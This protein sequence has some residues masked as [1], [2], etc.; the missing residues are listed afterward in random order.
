MKQKRGFLGTTEVDTTDY[1]TNGKGGQQLR[2]NETD[3]YAEL[4]LYQEQLALSDTPNEDAELYRKQDCIWLCLNA[5]DIANGNDELLRKGGRIIADMRVSG[6]LSSP[7]ATVNGEN[8]LLQ[9]LCDDLKRRMLSDTDAP[10]ADAEF[11]EWFETEVVA[12]NYYQ[13]LDGSKTKDIPRLFGLGATE[14]QDNY[15]KTVKDCGLNFIY[16]IQ[17]T[18]DLYEGCT[19]ER[20]IYNKKKRQAETINWFATSGT[21]MTVNSLKKN[22]LAGCMAKTGKKTKKDC[23][24]A[25]KRDCNGEEDVAV[26]GL[27]ELFTLISLIVAAVI[28]IVSVVLSIVKSKREAQ[29][30]AA[31]E[32]A[33]KT[34]TEEELALQAPSAGDYN[35]EEL[36]KELQA[37]R[38]MAANAQSSLSAS[39]AEEDHTLLYTLLGVGGVSVL[40]L[41]AAL[42]IRKKK[43]AKAIDKEKK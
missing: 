39:Q 11:E 12:F 26:N 40:G 27:G 37:A 22:V 38:E 32:A 4:D 2:C 17:D 9:Q 6:G 31:V 35:T 8:V 43:K 19:N 24:D 20:D 10:T 21:N 25:L 18:E 3:L 1:W 16:T 13:N 30:Q 29:L 36:E 33:S 5:I 34:P 14:T 42:R 7:F 15:S 23:L 41:V 28:M